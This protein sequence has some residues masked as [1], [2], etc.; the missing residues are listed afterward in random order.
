MVTTMNRREYFQFLAATVLPAAVRP[1]SLELPWLLPAPSTDKLD[2]I[3][4]QLYTVRG[5][6]GKDVERTLARVAEIGYREVEFAGYFNREPKAVR[7]ALDAV[8]LA[9]PS[10]HVPFESLEKAWRK[11]LDDAG[12][13]GHRYLVVPWIPEEQ[14]QGAD[15]YRR[16]GEMFNRAGEEAKKAGIQF[17]Y[18]NHDFEFPPVEGRVPYDVLLESTDPALVH[19]EL[20]LYWIRFAGGDP[21]AYFTR[22]PGRFALVHVKDMDATPQHGMVDV[23]SGVIDFKA[24]FAQRAQAGIRHFFVEHDNP[25]SPFDS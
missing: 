21:L 23:G 7:A 24:I 4:L 10:A 17:G 15:G 1:R 16:V 3:G 6:M 20:D 5:E 18:H 13:V 11:T 9:A 12:V 19:M 14:R 25:A 22:Y 2:R 8:G